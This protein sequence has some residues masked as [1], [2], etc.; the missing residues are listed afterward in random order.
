MRES[1][2]AAQALLQQVEAEARQLEG[3]ESVVLEAARSL[4]ED[5]DAFGEHVEAHGF[6]GRR[7]HHFDF[8]EQ[9]RAVGSGSSV[10][11]VSALECSTHTVSEP[12]GWSSTSPS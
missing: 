1:A 5:V 6:N 4:D 9:L 7:A 8:G 11:A 10:W 12:P 3:E 2:D